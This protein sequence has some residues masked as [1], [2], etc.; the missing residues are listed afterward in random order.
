MGEILYERHSDANDYIYLYKH[1]T[2]EKVSA[3]V[4]PHFHNAVEMKFII[5]GRYFTSVGSVK[6][7]IGAGEIIFVNSRQIHYYYNLGKTEYYTVVFDQRFLSN[8]CGKGRVFPNFMQL[9]EK[10]F[11]FIKE[12]F[13][14]MYDDWDNMS[15]SRKI[16]FI[17]RLIGT[18]A[19]YYDSVEAQVDDSEHMA[20]NI[21]Q[22]IQEHYA[23]DLTLD[24]LSQKFGYTR[25]YFSYLFHKYIGMNLREYLNRRRID[26]AIKLLEEKPGVPLY[27]VAEKVGYKSWVTFYRAY[28]KY[29]GGG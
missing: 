16:G 26:A 2:T 10:A 5:S 6:K 23:E 15:K 27:A 29:G 19:Q 7:E 13:E 8:V 21:M 3:Q 4:K 18:V 12:M 25:N 17:Y 11:P 20:I 28:L 9:S 22:Y 1:N 24:S 14:S